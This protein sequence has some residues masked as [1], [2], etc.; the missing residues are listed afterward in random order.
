MSPA[1]ILHMEN[2][3]STVRQ[4]YDRSP[5]DDLNDFGVNN[6]VWYIFMNVTL[7][8]AVHLGRDF[9]ENLRFTKNQL[10]MS[11]QQLFQVTEKFIMDQTEVG[12]LT[13][14]EYT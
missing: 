8:A 11:V 14:M 5:A 3:Y 12:G 2:V 10:A 13:A 1:E 6:A 7:Q 9:S 4:V